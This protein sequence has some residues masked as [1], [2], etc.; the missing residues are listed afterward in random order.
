MIREAIADSLRTA[1]KEQHKKR[2]ATLRLMN[3]AINDYDIAQRG[4]GKDRADES[5]VIDILARMVKQREESARA[6]RDGGREDLAE[7][8]M[9]EMAIIREF[10]PPQLSEAETAEAVDAA[11]A[12]AEAKSLRDMGKVMS[13]LKE[14][15]RGRM[16][17][18]DA[19]ALIK[20]KLGK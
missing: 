7:R 12:E 2:V 15:Y 19:G 18:G 5:E 1:Q 10:L 9:Y 16:D 8:E 20:Q 4:K 14:R 13:L 11:I 6:Y 17:M 3:A